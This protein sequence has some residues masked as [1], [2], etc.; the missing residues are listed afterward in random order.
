MEMTKGW[1]ELECAQYIQILNSWPNHANVCVGA[2]SEGF[3][4]WQWLKGGKGG[5][6]GKMK[7]TYLKETW[8]EPKE[9]YR[10]L[11]G[12]THTD[13]RKVKRTMKGMKAKRKWK[14]NASKMTANK[15]NVKRT[16]MRVICMGNGTACSESEGLITYDDHTRVMSPRLFCYFIMK[17]VTGNEKRVTRVRMLPKHS[18]IEL[19]A[20]PYKFMSWSL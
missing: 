9:Y 7:G 17:I 13:K 12:N 6:G 11:H 1:A 3:A 4:G 14:N 5:K 19:V 16:W 2:F 15:R 10:E 8:T 20:K 18:N